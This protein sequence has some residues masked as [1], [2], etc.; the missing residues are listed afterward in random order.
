[1]KQPSEILS[2]GTR[3]IIRGKLDTPCYPMNLTDRR[4]GASGT[5]A[6]TVGGFGGDVYRVDHEDGSF[7]AYCWSE[8]DLL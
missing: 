4:P 6:F 8:F 1:M 7:G 5:I 2:K 3:V